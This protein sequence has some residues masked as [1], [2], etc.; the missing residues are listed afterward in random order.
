[1]MRS[2]Q[3]LAMACCFQPLAASSMQRLCARNPVVMMLTHTAAGPDANGSDGHV[4]IDV[5][6]YNGARCST[7]SLDSYRDD[8][9]HGQTDWF[10]ASDKGWGT[11]CS[12]TDFGKQGIKKIQVRLGGNDG[13]MFGWAEVRL[14]D[15]V[16]ARCER[17]TWLDSKATTVFCD[18][19]ANYSPEAFN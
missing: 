8:Y 17:K 5:W 1:M 13:W 15:G 6:G 16:R 3:I 4:Y 18:N 11:S 7:G 10:S 9:E 19:L 12:T 14:Q 2:I